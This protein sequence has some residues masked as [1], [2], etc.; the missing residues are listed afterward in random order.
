MQI[1]PQPALSQFYMLFLLLGLPG[2]IPVITSLDL[3]QIIL[4]PLGGQPG[5]D[6]PGQGER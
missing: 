1:P 4:P 3:P 6:Q 5:N 2:I